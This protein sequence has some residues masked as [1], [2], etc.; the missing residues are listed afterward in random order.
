MFRFE[1]MNFI[2]NVVGGSPLARKKPAKGPPKAPPKA[3]GQALWPAIHF[4]FFVG[5]VGC[6]KTLF[7]VVWFFGREGEGV[8]IKENLKKYKK[9]KKTCNSGKK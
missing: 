1:I 6:G 4:F 9:S 7:L 3:L 5:G 8:E 2:E